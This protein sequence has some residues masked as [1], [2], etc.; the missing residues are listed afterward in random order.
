MGKEEGKKKLCDTK[1]SQVGKV[2]LRERPP[3]AK[4][5]AGMSCPS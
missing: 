4:K 1:A 5:Q 3:H 2:A